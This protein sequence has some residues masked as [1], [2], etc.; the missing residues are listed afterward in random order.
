MPGDAKMTSVDLPR[1]RI[2]FRSEEEDESDETGLVADVQFEVRLAKTRCPDTC[3]GDCFAF[4]WGFWGRT[5][6][7]GGAT[8][9]HE[10]SLLIGFFIHDSVLWLELVFLLRA[11]SPRLALNA[12]ASNLTFP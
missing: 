9:I 3:A 4:D 11:D 12:V 8:G 1:F 6:A 5:D 2:E 10:A 7:T